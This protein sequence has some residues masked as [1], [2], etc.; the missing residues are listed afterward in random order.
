MAKNTL[1]VLIFIASYGL[2]ASASADTWTLIRDGKTY[3][4]QITWNRETGHLTGGHYLGKSDDGSQFS[5]QMFTGRG[6]KIIYLVQRNAMDFYAVYS[7]IKTAYGTFE[8]KFYATSNTLEH[9][10]KI[11]VEAARK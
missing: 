2:A 9:T 1:I 10:F 7:G 5:G 11:I 6:R 8:G 3:E 4:I